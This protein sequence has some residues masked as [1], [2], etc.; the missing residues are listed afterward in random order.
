MLRRDGFGGHWEILS[1]PGASASAGAI[2][3]VECPVVAYPHQGAADLCA[4]YGLTSTLHA[5]GEACGG[6]ACYRCL[7][8]IAAC[9]RAALKVRCRDRLHACGH[10]RLPAGV[11]AS[12]LLVHASP[13]RVMSPS[14]SKQARAGA[15]RPSRPCLVAAATLLLPGCHGF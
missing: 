4:A 14:R 6:A 15:A 2:L 9:A 10:E 11:L 12:P 1:A 13:R 5:F 7:R 8:A 3:T